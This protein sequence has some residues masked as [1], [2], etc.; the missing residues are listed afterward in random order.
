MVIGVFIYSCQNQDEYS[1]EIAGPFAE[2]DISKLVDFKGLPVN[3]RFAAPIKNLESEHTELVLEQ[4]YRTSRLAMAEQKGMT[5]VT[6]NF[7]FPD[8][9][10][11]A[12][13]TKKVLKQFPYG[14]TGEEKEAEQTWEMIKQDFPTLTEAEIDTNIDLIEEYYSQNLDF[15]VLDEIAKDANVVAGK[16]SGS[17]ENCVFKKIISLKWG[18]VKATYAIVLASKRAR[19]SAGNY[20][21]SADGIGGE[22]TRGDAYRHILWSAL[23][24][25]YYFTISSKVKRIKFAKAVVDA[26]EECNDFNTKDGAVMDYHNNVIGRKIWDENTSYRKNWFGW[27]Y[28]LKT[29]STSRIKDLALKALESNSCFIVKEKKDDVFPNNLLIQSR[30]ALQ[31][32]KKIENTNA[33]TTVYFQGTI[34]P[35]RYEWVKVFIGYEYYDCESNNGIGIRKIGIKPNPRRC[36]RAVYKSQKKEI[37]SNYEL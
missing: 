23:L 12:K 7:E 25:D 13:A 10:L 8:A 32:K 3:H 35:S 21:S 27:I 16:V 15:L 11:I 2:M 26:N 28:G 14:N 18:F 37:I 5:S 30:T 6:E 34:V 33:N 1:F 4:M 24:A 22:N 9:E 29:P 19:A 20:Y 17:K 31:I 36:R